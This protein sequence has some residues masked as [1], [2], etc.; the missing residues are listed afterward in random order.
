M[1]TFMQCNIRNKNWPS[2]FSEPKIFWWVHFIPWFYLSCHDLNM[3]FSQFLRDFFI[4][5]AHLKPYKI[6]RRTTKIT[7]IYINKW[8]EPS[9]ERVK[10]KFKYFEHNFQPIQPKHSIYSFIFRKTLIYS[11]NLSG[12][13]I[14]LQ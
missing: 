8:C 5:K 10:E 14:V 7:F 12:N 9:S 1:Q 4:L 11:W 3:K 6:I 2:R 13:E